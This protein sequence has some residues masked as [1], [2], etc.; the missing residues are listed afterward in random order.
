MYEQPAANQP[1]TPRLLTI[2]QAAVYLS[3]AVWAVRQLCW[4]RRLRHIKLGN[5]YVIP[6]EE[7]D[8]YINEQLEAFDEES[9]VRP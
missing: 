2:K 3:S 8:R 1:V 7:L 4:S 6:R 9:A 5:K